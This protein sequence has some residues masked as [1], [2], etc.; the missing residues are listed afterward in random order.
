[1][2]IHA[3]FSR[4]AM[5]LATEQEWIHS[6]EYGVDRIMLDRI[7]E[8]VA[9]ATSIVRYAPNS[10]FARHEH[11][12]GEE[13][14]VLCG[15]F[16]DE[17][18]DYPA[19]TYVRNPPGTGHTPFS[20]NGCDILVKLRQFDP[21]DLQPVVVH[22]ADSSVWPSAIDQPFTTLA[23]HQFDT[24]KVQMLRLPQ[25]CRFSAA[26]EQGGIELLVVEGSIDFD[27]NSLGGRA[28][29]RLPSDSG[30]EIVAEQD[31]VLW[32]KSGHLPTA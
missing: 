31:S 12:L 1:M 14:L 4:S 8:E 16:S 15:V 25:G 26:P 5:L 22:T 7:G 6:P 29:L 11:A 13:F 9:R 28:W 23:L 10:S 30:L 32:M 27:N 24:E 20:K 19:G 18:G 21:T 3:D 2:R 17:H